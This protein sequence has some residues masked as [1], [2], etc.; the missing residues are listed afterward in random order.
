MDYITWTLPS[1]NLPVTCLNMEE[2]AAVR[3]S[4]YPL[5][6]EERNLS[7]VQQCCLRC[8]CV[9][10]GLG[11]GCAPGGTRRYLLCPD[12]LFSPVPAAEVRVTKFVGD[13]AAVQ[14]A[15]MSLTTAPEQ[16]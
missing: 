2:A 11:R 10:R 1:N 4:F 12:R 6:A 15:V 8:G 3:C 9:R 16:R 7:R 5:P 14:A 13:T